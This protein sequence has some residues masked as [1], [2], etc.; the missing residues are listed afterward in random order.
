MTRRLVAPPSDIEFNHSFFMKDIF[1][2]ALLACIAVP[3]AMQAQMVVDRK[4]YP[5]YSTV[6]RP[7]SSL[8]RY[9]PKRS[10]R[11]VVAS[12]ISERPMMVNNANTKHFP[13]IFNQ[14]G[15]S[16]GSAS[17]IGYMFTHE[18]N[19]YRDADAS[20]MLNRYP[21]HFVWLHTSGNSG[22]DQFVQFIGVPSAQ[23]Y[24]S[25]TYSPLFGYQEETNNNFGWM[26]GYEK[27][28]EAM[29]NRMLQPF[30]L[31]MSVETEEGREIL[32]NWLWNHNGDPDFHSG[33]IVGIGV[34]SGGNWKKIP[35]TDANNAAHV[36]GMWYVKEW[37]KSV[38]HALT[39][40]GY[41]D[42][43][44]FDLDDNGIAGEV[45]KDEVGAW[46]VAN[47]W[48]NGWCNRGFIYCPYA[49]ATPVQTENGKVRGWYQPE[50]YR[51]RKNYRPLRTIKVKMDYSHR[52]EIML[53]V[54]VAS[55]LNAKVPERTLELEYFRFAGDGK[56]G[57]DIP[58]PAV[59]MLGRWAD[60]KLHDEP[61]EF[62]YDLTD[63]TTGFDKSK[64]L[65]YFFNVH[66]T[67]RRDR[68]KTSSNL[69][70]GSGH[71][72]Y[73]AIL[74][75]EHD[76]QGVETPF[77]PGENKVVEVPG[78]KITTITAIVYGEQYYAPQN[79]TLVD[80]KLNWQKPIKSSHAIKHYNIY[81]DGVKIGTSE[82][83][84]YDFSGAGLYAV[85]AIY[86]NNVESSKIVFMA[87]VQ[88]QITNVAADLKT[89]GFVIPDIFSK[90]FDQV[91]IEYWIKPRKLIDWN[92]SAGPGWGNFLCHA[93]RSG[94]FSAG[95]NTNGD[96]VRTAD[97]TLRKNVWTHVAMV[98]ARS[99]FRVHIN[100]GTATY[101][102][103][104]KYSGLGGFGNL[105]FHAGGN[106][107]NDAVYD[108]I[109]IWSTA[110]S[111]Y[112]IRDAYKS[113]FSGEVMPT[114][115]LAY[116]K[117]DI[118]DIN[119]VPH[120]R[121]CVGGHHAPISNE[122][123]SNYEQVN[124]ENVFKKGVDASVNQSNT[125][126]VTANKII[127][128]QPTE[129]S[130][131]Y[132][133]AVSSL[134]WT[135][136]AAGLH[137]V[138]TAAPMVVFPK[139]GN[140]TVT[141]TASS[142]DGKQKVIVNKEVKVEEAPAPDATFVA[143]MSQVAAGQRISFIPNKSID[144]YFYQWDMPGAELTTSNAI[145]AA[146]QYNLFGEYTVTLTVTSP[147]GETATSSQKVKVLKVAPEAD[148]RIKDPVV[149]KEQKTGFIDASKF[150]PSSWTWLI[151]SNGMS[152]AANGQNPNFSI[153]APGVYDVTLMVKNEAGV[154][155]KT[156]ERALTVVNAL[157]KNGLS[158]GQNAR[159]KM[160]QVPIAKDSENITVE[161][162]MN[163]G[164]L[165]DDCC[166]I[167]DQESTFFIKVDAIGK[168]IV[169]RNGRSVMSYTDV[170]IPGQWHHYAV[171]FEKN[172][173]RIYRDGVQMRQGVIVGKFPD[174]TQFNISNDAA[175][176]NGQIDEFR[177]W[178]TALSV[179]KIRTYANEPIIDTK[180]AEEGKDKLLLYY[181]FNQNGGAV[182]DR[183]S[184]GNK[185]IRTGFG[186]DGDAWGLSN[187]V[188]SLNYEAT[189]E[190]VT[191][192]YL[193]NYRKSFAHTTKQINN[194]QSGRWY[195]LKD[196]KL[197]NTATT[198]DGK[199]ISGVHMDKQKNNCFTFTTGWDNFPDLANHK[200]YQV[201][202]LPAGTYTFVSIYDGQYGGS[203]MA[204][205]LVAA[206]GGTLPD[207]D[208]LDSK[209]LAYGE[210]T[211]AGSNAVNSVTFTLPE[212]T[213][214]ALGLV[215]N[216]SGN[217]IASI[218]Q[219]KLMYTPLGQLNAI[220]KVETDI[221]KNGRGE[222]YDLSGRRIAQPQKGHIY[223]QNGQ[224][225]FVK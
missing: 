194:T 133:D 170:V 151:K 113:E 74:D 85:S 211:S 200:A 188:F 40:V 219:F 210:M 221:L 120:L 177:I 195:E 134:V 6:I 183:T 146:T 20:S 190:D 30:N 92:N 169:Y 148:F 62:G 25:Q 94:G 223:I 119:G 96:R 202:T 145:T 88:P 209:A 167:G 201:V 149:L 199:I 72:H 5:D 77:F 46:I 114:G 58:A 91:T 29:H 66:A 15:G 106:S 225:I 98:V 2:L 32:K 75:Y 57:D 121:D 129:I 123:A 164:K 150:N 31:P 143:S 41:D 100:G 102:T 142:F 156:M 27:W 35:A 214:V 47:S 14:D 99:T 127:A 19:S 90:H 220:G 172:I 109:R 3:S 87:P 53:T 49:R 81:K 124:N 136:E 193:V 185:G 138:K 187:G 116:Y 176:M 56:N 38:D 206:I 103:S 184:T 158:F 17:R 76:H 182:E 212:E 118:I 162:W 26:T 16:C 67:T 115:L 117:G 97:G 180:A 139:S 213:E 161:W 63:L 216:M 105:V 48:G 64:P 34:A 86:E 95:W 204:S 189:V 44:E 157:S 173:V 18:I 12:P 222:L 186:P 22:K 79:L 93:D 23:T 128:G 60:G 52:S 132:S 39:I 154:S 141:L 137:N 192:K 218:Q 7:D 163:P 179:E 83:N 126:I 55:D 168:L 174:M 205:Y 130:A 80:G 197:E 11:G 131:T 208:M 84:T 59:P 112:H 65:K 43:I 153:D 61:M 166:G 196:W 24:G 175:P 36:S 89:N 181:D 42:R 207:T 28:F 198:E 82:Q 54:G 10:S 144:G 13:P 68:N 8:L 178:G 224:R 152:Y 21:T 45:D 203:A 78:G 1:K 155:T 101:I 215:I 108:E 165:V 37:G 50:I 111:G 110:R 71:I 4:M 107:A 73:A 191:S 140:Y 147:S 159:I 70:K 171:T 9:T 125:K 217:S 104:R 33:G 51:V 160:E 69:A 135:I 122:M